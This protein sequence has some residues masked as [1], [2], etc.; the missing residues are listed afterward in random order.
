MRLYIFA[1]AFQ[2]SRQARKYW[3]RPYGF[4]HAGF[5][6]DHLVPGGDTPAVIIAEPMRIDHHD[7]RMIFR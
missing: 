5:M 2:N 3:W 6:T 1:S 7:G 4:S